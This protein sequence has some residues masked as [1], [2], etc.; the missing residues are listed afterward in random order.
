MSVDLLVTAL[1]GATTKPDRPYADVGRIV[2]VFDGGYY[3]VRLDGL[4]TET[5]EIGEGGFS[6][7]FLDWMRA[8]KQAAVGRRVLVLWANQ[9]P[10][11]AFALGEPYAAT[12]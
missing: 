2:R 10:V 11:I 3:S 9:Q 1:V 8:N 5:F 4:L 7:P 6:Q 12:Q